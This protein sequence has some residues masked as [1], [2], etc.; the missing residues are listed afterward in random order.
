MSTFA[1][2]AVDLAGAPT[3]GE[4][5]GDD[6]QAVASQLRTRGLI[7]VDIE[8]QK[9]TEVG[10]LFAKWRRVKA[11][12]LTVA[13]RQLAT[14]ISS[15]MSMLRALYV[16]EEQV[17]SEKLRLALVD[18][19]KDVEAGLALSDALRRHPAIF[20]ELFVAMVQAGET[21]GKLEETLKR[22]ADQLEKDDALR[23]KVKAAMLYPA[24]IIGFAF[25]V[26]IALV[27]FLI[28]VF[29][30]VFKEFGGELPAITK[31]TVG[32]S[33]LVTDRWYFLIAGAIA[34]IFLFIKWKKSD[35]GKKQWDTFKLRIPWKIGE[36]VHKVAL[37]RF[38]RT[39]SALV[40]AGVPML[41]AIDITGRTAGNWVIEKGMGDILDS[42]KRGGTI[43][44]P[45]RANPKAFPAMVTQMVATGEETG[46]LETM[47]TKIADFYEDQVDT[48][49]KALT[50]LLE[51]L[52][53]IVVGAI[54]GFIIISMYLP[55][56]TVYDNIR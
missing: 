31:V 20:N 49:I 27:A 11:E 1:F 40:S 6:K 28:P 3:H 43:A 14:M 55:M 53:I 18:V 52:M 2:K 16:V 51:P 46:A 10:D 38:S 8:E 4:I 32:I 19:R 29:E 23:R 25:V 36:V 41:E 34:A 30:D 39:F 56:F 37:A 12:H 47:F 54:V 22:V 17:E 42:V 50:S 26:V 7:V 33:H 24:L 5:D 9:P 48:A 35:A 21:G 13:T 15:G 45:M 44:A